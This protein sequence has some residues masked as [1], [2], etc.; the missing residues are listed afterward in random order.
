MSK[1]NKGIV[2]LPLLA[3]LGIVSV[4]VGMLITTKSNM[5]KVDLLRQDT[6]SKKESIFVEQKPVSPAPDSEIDKRL[7][8]LKKGEAELDASFNDSPVTDL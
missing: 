7:N 2:S 6:D 5:E 1:S 4:V 3:V 8:D